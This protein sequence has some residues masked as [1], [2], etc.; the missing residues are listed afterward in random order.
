MSLTCADALQLN[1]GTIRD[2]AGNSAII[3][4]SAIA[5]QSTTAVDDAVS[6]STSFRSSSTSISLEANDSHALLTG[7]SAT[8]LIGN[9][10]N[11]ILTGNQAAN[12]ISAGLGRDILTGGGG[13]DQFRINNAIESRLGSQSNSIDW[14]R[15]FEVGVDQIIGPSGT[16]IQQ[17]VLM[18][19]VTQLSNAAIGQ[20]LNTTRFASD[21]PAA[22]FTLTGLDGTH[23]YLAVNN[24]IS[25]FN[26]QD[27]VLLEITGLRGALLSST[28]I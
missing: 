6:F 21:V 13:A 28:E 1:Q 3:T 8:T 5:A 14:I 18:G 12:S 22:A 24:G 10:S 15:D 23:T 26:A 27:D 7:S 25:G 4:T 16:T 19:A 9:I 2:R 17:A 20:L 11:N